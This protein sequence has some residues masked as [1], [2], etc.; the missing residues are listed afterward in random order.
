M[1]LANPIASKTIHVKNPVAPCSKSTIVAIVSTA[2][3]VKRH[4]RTIATPRSCWMYES[5]LV[6]RIKEVDGTDDEIA[7]ILHGMLAGSGTCDFDFLTSRAT[8]LLNCPERWLA[9]HGYGATS[10]YNVAS[11]SHWAGGRP[12]S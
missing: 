12:G 4:K 1:L 3:A 5:F 7:E 2:F 6:Y 10:P 11:G 9:G 8:E